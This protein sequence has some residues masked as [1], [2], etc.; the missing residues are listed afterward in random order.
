MAVVMEKISMQKPET[1]TEA[2]ELVWMIQLI[3]NLFGGMCA[4]KQTTA[5]QV[6]YAAV[7]YAFDLA[8]L[9]LSTIALVG[10]T[11]NAFLYFRF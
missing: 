3:G 10:S 7:T 8:L 5:G 6:V 4:Q 11:Y 1:F 2:I 9:A